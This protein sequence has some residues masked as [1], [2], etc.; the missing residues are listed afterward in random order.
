[1]ILPVFQI[2]TRWFPLD[3]RSQIELTGRDRAKFLHNFCTQEIKQL[4]A[5][6]AC[7]AFI[8]NVKGRI[9]GHVFVFA[10]ETSLWIDTVPDQT[11]ALIAHLDKYRITEDVEFHDRTHAWSETFL[12]GPKAVTS[13]ASLGI[14]A[15]TMTAKQHTTI[16]WRGTPLQLRR[17]DWFGGPG[18]LL[19]ALLPLGEGGRR[20]DEGVFIRDEENKKPPHVPADCADLLRTAL[21]EASIPQ[22]SHDEFEALRIQLGLPHYGIDL[23]DDNLAQEA[24]R[25]RTAISFKKGCYLGQEP[26]ARIDALGHVNRELRSLAIETSDPPPPDTPVFSEAEGKEIGKIT[27]AAYSEA[28][29]KTYAMA[30]L[31]SRF[32]APRTTVRIASPEGPPAK[33]FWS[34]DA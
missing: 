4:A 18:F 23:T 22:G 5:G 10:N 28:D 34:P 13:L 8:T 29:Q 26:I 32:T 24:G 14:D 30:L 33:V 1:M 21:N 11:A 31:Q 9:L 6:A 17:V 25:T 3:R 15:S 20:P 27:S 7:E 2:D 16:D 19:D 12:S